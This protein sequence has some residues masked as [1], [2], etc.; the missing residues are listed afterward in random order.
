M[1]KSGKYGFLAGLGNGIADVGK[2]VYANH[3]EEARE[4]RLRQYEREN[5]ERDRS[6]R[7]EDIAQA[8]GYQLEDYTRAR[9]DDL[10]DHDRDRKEALEDDSRKRGYELQDRAYNASA[11]TALMHAKRALEGDDV[12]SVQEAT[13][14]TVDEFGNKIEKTVGYVIVKKSGNSEFLDLQTG[15]KSPFQGTGD[16]QSLVGKDIPVPASAPAPAATTPKQAPAPAAVAPEQVEQVPGKVSLGG[17]HDPKELSNFLEQEAAR[18]DQ[19]REEARAHKPVSPG[20][21]PAESHGGAPAQAP[22]PWQPP[23]GDIGLLRQ[24]MPR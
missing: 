16:L 12:K 23:K 22:A 6:E 14:P 18:L 3:I 11:A 7:K 2:L 1:S 13:V 4:A 8:R 21:A 10:S 9:K 24:S 17:F 20:M 15:K 5:H 19:R